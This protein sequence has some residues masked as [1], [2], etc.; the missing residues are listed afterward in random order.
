MLRRLGQFTMRSGRTANE[1][2]VQLHGL[3]RLFTFPQISYALCL[4][5]NLCCRVPAYLLGSR[6]PYY[7]PNPLV[8]SRDILR[9]HHE[10]VTSIG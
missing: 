6:Y 10:D 1:K 7:K 5:L 4:L 9:A 8:P 3:A 2:A